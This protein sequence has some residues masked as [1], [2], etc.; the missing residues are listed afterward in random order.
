M[1]SVTPTSPDLNRIRQL[2]E[3]EIEGQLK[4][5]D[6]AELESHFFA[7]ELARYFIVTYRDMHAALIESQISESGTFPVADFA[8]TDSEIIKK[9]DEQTTLSQLQ[10][11]IYEEVIVLAEQYLEGRLLPEK[12]ERL[13]QLICQGVDGRK[14]FFDYL[15]RHAIEQFRLQQK[16]REKNSRLKAEKYRIPADERWKYILVSVIATSVMFS[17]GM[18]LFNYGKLLVPQVATICA[19]SDDATL[20]SGELETGRILR[21]L[22]DLTL[23]TGYVTL[24]YN[25]GVLV[26]LKAPLKVTLSSSN[27]LNLAHGEIKALVPGT[28]IG[29]QVETP[30]A[31]I[32]DL[33]TEFL[34]QHELGHETTVT[35]RQ[36]KVEVNQLDYSQSPI[37][38]MQVD[39]GQAAS[40]THRELKLEGYD[41]NKYQSIDQSRRGVIRLEGVTRL[42]SVNLSI[43]TTGTHP[44]NNHVLLVPEQQR[45]SLKEAMTVQSTDGPVQF[46][47]GDIV[48]SY[49]LHF[50][51]EQ[52]K[53]IVPPIGAVEF[54]L[55]ITAIVADGAELTHLDSIVG[56]TDGLYQTEDYRGL[57]LKEHDQIDLSTDRKTLIYHLSFSGTKLL[58]QCRILIREGNIQQK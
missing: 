54:S 10:E 52:T 57:E 37:R 33:G 44:T 3:L 6:A 39:A 56:V 13:G 28:A 41:E 24:K 21:H 51:P 19:L 2:L 11:E 5:G 46:N 32:I 12:W 40:V 20:V 42:D 31:Q 53:S 35:V 9:W 58:D 50:D 43:L 47:A 48:S 55:P 34:V 29:F 15:Q 8:E 17:A 1:T 14:V 22:D 25:S 26:D 49:L 27:K 45:L 16:A 18:W 30:T 38:Q 4:H 23:K 36:G 7:S